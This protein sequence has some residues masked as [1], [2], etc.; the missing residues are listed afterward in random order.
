[1][2][3]EQVMSKFKEKGIEVTVYED[4]IRGIVDCIVDTTK[5]DKQVRENIIDECINIIENCVWKDSEML[6]D[7]LK[8]LKEQ[9]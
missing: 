3:S 2:T 6:V 7:M 9:K 8:E 1:M 5:H 4:K